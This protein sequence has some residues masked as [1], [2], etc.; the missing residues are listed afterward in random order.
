M[1]PISKHAACDLKCDVLNQSDFVASVFPAQSYKLQGRATDHYALAAF[2]S[3]HVPTGVAPDEP[4]PDCSSLSAGKDSNAPSVAYD[5][6]SLI[7][8]DKMGKAF[9][10]AKCMHL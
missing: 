7:N 1:Q 8:L 3:H 10:F 5:L 6:H 2:V 9:V 4:F